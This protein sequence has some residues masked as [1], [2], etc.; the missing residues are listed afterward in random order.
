MNKLG[1]SVLK[2]DDKIICI[3]IMKVYKVYLYLKPYNDIRLTT[4][5]DNALLFSY[6]NQYV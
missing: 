1:K 4:I 6:N 2:T 3:N 5:S